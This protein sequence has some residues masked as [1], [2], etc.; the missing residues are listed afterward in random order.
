MYRTIAIFNS[1]NVNHFTIH[2]IQ[3]IILCYSMT[4]HRSSTYLTEFSF[5]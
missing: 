5:E 3:T 2:N 1:Q 4:D